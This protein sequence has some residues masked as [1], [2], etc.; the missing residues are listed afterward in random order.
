MFAEPVSPFN[1]PISPGSNI[2]PSF[3]QT[4]PACKRNA[5]STPF[6]VSQLLFIYSI[7]H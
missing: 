4:T 3:V 2:S 7:V 1:I 6:A 5:K